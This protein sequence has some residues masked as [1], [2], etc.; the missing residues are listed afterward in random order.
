VKPN[1]GQLCAVF[2]GIDEAV[3]GCR[4]VR[5]LRFQPLAAMSGLP[6]RSERVMSFG[7]PDGFERYMAQAKAMERLAAQMRG[8]LSERDFSALVDSQKLAAQGAQEV[9]DSPT[10][11]ALEG[12]EGTLAQSVALRAIEDLDTPGV[13]DQATKQWRNAMEAQRRLDDLTGIDRIAGA[14]SDGSVMRQL[15]RA[16][17]PLS[18]SL[19]MSEQISGR[20]LVSKAFDILGTQ[21]LVARYFEASTA[22]N[23]LTRRL[24]DIDAFQAQLA[25]LYPREIS[26]IRDFLTDDDWAQAPPADAD[27]LPAG[28]VDLEPW[29]VFLGA[30]VDRLVKLSKVRKGNL[31]KVTLAM[32]LFVLW[33]LLPQLPGEV[34]GLLMERALE[35]SPSPLTTKPSERQLPAIWIHAPVVGTR[36]VV[37]RSGPSGSQRVL[38]VVP[39]GMPLGVEKAKHGWLYLRFVDPSGD[40]GEVKGW[41]RAKGLRPIPPGVRRALA[42]QLDGQNSPGDCQR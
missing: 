24:V 13:V 32:S 9:L 34:M 28:H 1:A 29:I 12:I 40:G 5:I 4:W 26:L 7:L 37:L 17:G 36:P 18:A 25:R 41:A 38:M 23:N 8:G 20:D 10:L 6:L 22:T 15:E 16:M 14:L 33:K 11:R 30:L 39:A 19:R 3:Q 31:A 42:C 35:P 2:H 27:D 21:D